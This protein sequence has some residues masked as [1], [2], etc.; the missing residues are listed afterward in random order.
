M[1]A[2]APTWSTEYPMRFSCQPHRF[3]C[4]V[5]LHARTMYLCVL[6]HQ[7]QVVLER[8]PPANPDA[9]RTTRAGT[10]SMTTL[11]M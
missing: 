6:D 5:D 2:Q 9:L 1:Q 11:P 7:G 3:Y 10:T 8:N 4:G